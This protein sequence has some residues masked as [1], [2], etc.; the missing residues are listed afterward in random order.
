MLKTVT[1]KEIHQRGNSVTDV[2]EKNNNA[3]ETGKG[4]RME[5]IQ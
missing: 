4:G 2:P 1:I 5:Y 3:T